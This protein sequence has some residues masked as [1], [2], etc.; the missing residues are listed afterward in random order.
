MALGSNASPAR[1]SGRRRGFLVLGILVLLLDIGGNE[2]VKADDRADGAQLRNLAAVSGFDLGGC[3]LHLG[4]RHL[5]SD[6][7]FPDDVVKARLIGINHAA[8]HGRGPVEIGRADGL[9]RF[10]GVWPWR[11]IGEA[12]RADIARRI[13]PGWLPAPP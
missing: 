9:V 7:P 8:H 10:L 3:P 5:R 12:F 4:A 2:T 6:R 1:I 13:R 11:C